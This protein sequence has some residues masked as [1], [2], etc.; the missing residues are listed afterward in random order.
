M[1]SKMR[2]FVFILLAATTVYVV[3]R[4]LEKERYES[5]EKA[6][7][8]RTE[9]LDDITAAKDALEGFFLALHEGDHASAVTFLGIPEHDMDGNAPSWDW[10][11]IF[12]P[13]ERREDKA[14]VLAEYCDAVR[15]CLPVVIEDSVRNEDDSFSFT[16]HFLKDDGTIFVLGPCCGATEEEMP[17]QRTFAFTVKKIEGIYKVMDV[18]VYVP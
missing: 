4:A 18:P 7:L 11:R 3:T 5:V 9:P 6:V 17:P 16:V 10:L 15:T 8:V 1:F 14:M 13:E 12:S 2:I